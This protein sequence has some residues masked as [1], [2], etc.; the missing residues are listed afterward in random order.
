MV[1]I[2]LEVSD[3]GETWDAIYLTDTTGSTAFV[4][5]DVPSGGVMRYVYTDTSGSATTTFRLS[6]I[7]SESELE[8]MSD[9]WITASQDTTQVNDAK[10]FATLR[11]E[12]SQ[13]WPF[14]SDAETTADFTNRLALVGP[15]ID[16]IVR[17]RVS[18]GAEYLTV[19]AS[20]DDTFAK[21]FEVVAAE[22][23]ITD[24]RG[25]RYV[26]K[27]RPA[28][29]SFKDPAT[30]GSCGRTWDDGHVTGVT[31][32]PSARCPFEGMRGHSGSKTAGTRED[33]GRHAHMFSVYRGCG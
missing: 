9:L 6:G 7:C 3:D 1:R 22:R 2:S 23:Y 8:L 16:D 21:D 31:P 30:C 4:V 25:V 20:L 15:Q 24:D 14:L 28:P 26:G 12:A 5:D 33:A 32:T 17:T 29:K 27:G 19:R 10:L 18:N 13:F 11:V